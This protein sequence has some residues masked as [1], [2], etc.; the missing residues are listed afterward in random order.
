MSELMVDGG[1][2][3][4]TI[5]SATRLRRTLE[6]WR[7]WIYLESIRARPYGRDDLP[8]AHLTQQHRERCEVEARAYLCGDPGR[9]DPVGMRQ[10]EGLLLE[11]AAR[12]GALRFH[13]TAGQVVTDGPLCGLL[14][15]QISG[16]VMLLWL[17]V[18]RGDVL[19]P[20]E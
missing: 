19:E 1:L 14:A 3:E 6:A 17:L 12:V 16:C 13:L 4:G 9:V 11:L 8:L 2:M 10:L 5:E 7:H 20:C 18:G 15:T